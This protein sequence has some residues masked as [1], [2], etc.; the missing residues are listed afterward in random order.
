[1][2]S[3]MQYIGI[4]IGTT[5]ISTIVFD[6]NTNKTESTCLPNNTWLSST[7]HWE[8]SQDPAEIIKLVEQSLSVFI[9]TNTEIKG[10]GITGQMHGIL[11]VDENG[12]AVS[13]LYTWQDARGNEIYKDNKTY[14]GYLSEVTG[15]PLATG[16]GLVTHFYNMVNNLVPAKARRFCTIMDYVVMRFAGLKEP[17]TDYSNG[18]SLGFFDVEHLA[19]DNNAL[20]KAG[21][22]ISF[23]P[24]LASLDI[25]CGYMDN[26]PVYPAIGDNQAAFMGSV[27]N[28]N[29]S[30]HITVGTSS[31]ISVYSE[32][33][34]KLPNL[35]TRPFPGGGYILVGAAL[36]GGQAFALLKNFFQETLSFLGVEGLE[37]D[38]IYKAM[39]SIDYESDDI[40]RVNT[41]F[42]GTRQDPAKKGSITGISRSNFTPKE[43]TIGFMK[44]IAKELL[45]FFHII[46]E[47]I[48]ADKTILVGSGNG[49]KKNPL[50]CKVFEETFGFKLELSLHNEEAAFGA[51]LTSIK[52]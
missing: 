34:I 44:G 24:R 6:Q 35:D 27:Q 2:P 16:Y 37:E 29:Q 41:L 36:C 38:I 13:P 20:E 46:P 47:K 9:S 51:C 43:L 17:L 23:L 50:L 4:D 31:Q 15:Y 1:M 25:P 21:I 14:A 42:D 28:I 3:N 8:K 19:F 22:D 11:Y 52:K 45:D 48:K 5:S 49:L 26:I 10:I 33:Y 40:L 30:V 39:T 32:K 12:N 7:Q 18:A